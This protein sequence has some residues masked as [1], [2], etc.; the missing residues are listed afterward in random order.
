MSRTLAHLL[1]GREYQILQ[2]VSTGAS[3]IRVAEE[4]GIS[5]HTVRNHLVHIYQKL[6][7]RS[8]WHAVALVFGS[9]DDQPGALTKRPT[10]LPVRSTLSRAANAG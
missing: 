2:R 6:G 4:L 3:N 9:L 7:A 1:T 8:R 5:S 10:L